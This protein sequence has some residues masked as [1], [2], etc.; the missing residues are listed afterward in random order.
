MNYQKEILNKLKDSEKWPGFDR[1]DFL[2]QL[3]EIADN[4][5]KKENVEGY[6]ASLLIYHQLTEELIKILIDCSTFYI[7]LSVFPQE[8]QKKELKRKMF[9][10]LIQELKHS[11]MDD[12]T[13]KLIQKSQELNNLR[14]R[15]VHKLT[16][17]S[18]I[19]NIKRQCKRVQ[20]LFNSILELFDEIYDD[21]RVTF[22]DFKKNID[23]LE[24]MIN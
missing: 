13:K 16:L 20:N 24:E 1:P 5:F 3:N 8:F 21:C 9:G 19:F 2:N 18:S 17:K 22:K 12:K 14:I 15:M 4:S 10:Q 11:V 7:Q 23:D 6:L